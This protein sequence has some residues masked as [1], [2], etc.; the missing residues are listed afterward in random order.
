M[1]NY[2]IFISNSLIIIGNKEI[3]PPE[4]LSWSD[5]KEIDNTDLEWIVNK[6]KSK[7]KLD[8]YILETNTPEV[9]F[10]NFSAN[11]KILQA[12]GGLVL[13]NSDKILMIHR[14]EHWDFPKGKVEKGEGIP[15]AAIREVM[16]ETGIGSATI[17]KELPNAYHIYE[18]ENKWVLK[19]TFWYLMHSGY[20][21][22]LIPQLEEDILAAVWVPLD[23][24]SEYMS[25]SYAGLRELVKDCKL[26]R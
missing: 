20:T 24:L 7:E 19:E 16:E 6:I 26:L 1:H 14:F 23:F 9:A 3:A 8:Y 25:Q 21:G 2:N 10:N 5:F 22:A 13:N 15:E 17:T 4:D 18:Y 12:A 11:F